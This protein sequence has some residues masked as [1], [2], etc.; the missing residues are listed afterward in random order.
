MCLGRHFEYDR[1]EFADHRR[2]Q[3]LRELPD[4]VAVEFEVVAEDWRERFKDV[5]VRA[6]TL[7]EHMHRRRKRKGQGHYCVRPTLVPRVSIP[8]QRAGAP[9]TA[10]KRPHQIDEARMAE[11][12]AGDAM[13][14]EYRE[15]VLHQVNRWGLA[16]GPQPASGEQDAVLAVQ[17]VEHNPG[18]REIGTNR[19]ELIVEV[20]RSAFWTAFDHT[21]QHLKDRV[22]GRNE[23]LDLLRS[24]SPF[25][26][27]A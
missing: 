21:D 24:H 10:S 19:L 12:L 15:Q 16:G 22:R 1:R 7:E 5:P 17:R 13:G 6:Q 25:S 26:P 11:C 27:C 14:F 20:L 8:I 4:L 3:L 9:P 2:C 18:L 23:C